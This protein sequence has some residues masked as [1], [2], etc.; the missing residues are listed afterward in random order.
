MKFYLLKQ[1]LLN[2]FIKN[3]YQKPNV[4]SSEQTIEYIIKNKDRIKI[5]TSNLS[6]GP[7]EEWERWTITSYAK[8]RI[9]EYINRKNNVSFY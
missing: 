8:T 2:C 9:R 6:L 3:F 4:M 7:T 1:V 5:I